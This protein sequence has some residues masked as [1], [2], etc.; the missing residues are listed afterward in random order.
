MCRA[1]QKAGIQIP[2]WEKIGKALSFN[3]TL[4]ITTADIFFES[5]RVYGCESQPSWNKLAQALENIGT[6]KYKQAAAY[7]QGK[8]G[9][10]QIWPILRTISTVHHSVLYFFCV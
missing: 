8:K 4:F 1:F 9:M 6:P 5:W 10:N 7:A 2:N 3:P